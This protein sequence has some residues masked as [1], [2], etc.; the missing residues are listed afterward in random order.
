LSGLRE[1]TRVHCL[2]T[3]GHFQPTR[4]SIEETGSS[5]TRF[6]FGGSHPKWTSPGSRQTKQKAQHKDRDEIDGDVRPEPSHIPTRPAASLQETPSY[7]P[8]AVWFKWPLS[9]SVIVIP[10]TSLRSVE[11]ALREREIRDSPC[12][13][14]SSV[15]TA[16][17]REEP[18][19]AIATSDPCIGGPHSPGKTR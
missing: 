14:W 7:P 11:E 8:H 5:V 16:R 3:G 6:L 4:A 13:F 18:L 2:S 15:M 1:K 19:P 17:N 9:S 10:Y 12:S